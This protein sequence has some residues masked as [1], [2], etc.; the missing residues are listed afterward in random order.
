MLNGLR[1]AMQNWLARRRS[2]AITHDPA[3]EFHEHEL[4][5]VEFETLDPVTSTM[6]PLTPG[7]ELLCPVT[8][9][10]LK[11]GMRMY[12]CQRCGLAYSVEGWEFLR[13]VEKGR[14]CGCLQEKSVFP[15]VPPRPE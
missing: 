13:T 12:R 3:M 15:Y 8:R 7:T 11:P 5:D 6:A 1:D 9:Q 2:D 14:C 10:P 4:D